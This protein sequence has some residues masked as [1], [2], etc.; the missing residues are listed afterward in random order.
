MPEEYPRPFE[1][2]YGRPAGPP[3]ERAAPPGRR[4][5]LHLSLFLLTVA[6]TVVA[7]AFLDGA[8][9]TDDPWLFW[10]GL[11]FAASLLLILGIHEMAHF[12]VSRRHGLEV[13]LPFF[14]PAPTLIG[15]M[16]AVIKI[17]SP[18]LD[19]R[20]LLDIGVS[21]PLAGFIV[22]LPLAAVGLSLSRV[23][24]LAPAAGESVALGSSL[25]FG[26][27]TDIAF[28][29]AGGADF[30]LVLHPVAFAAW[31]G[32]MVT[33]LNLLPIGQLDGGHVIAALFGPAQRYISLAF[34]AALVP[35][36]FLWQGWLV[37]AALL[38]IIGW[39][40]RLP[41]NMYEPLDARR[42]F[43]GFLCLFIFVLTFTPVPFAV[44]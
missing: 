23:V 20:A 33:A 13:T 3:P 32:M 28:P 12:I 10:R 26:F 17:K 35:L 2:G 34:L 25:L 31:V 39:R 44:R 4:L 40:H 42:R 30:Q 1:N 15:T 29:G 21:G 22:S 6:S 41:P 16:G 7:G 38:L 14:I 24:P 8:D 43:L 11:P 18:I 19:R 36:G 27:M 9:L 37:W 5:G